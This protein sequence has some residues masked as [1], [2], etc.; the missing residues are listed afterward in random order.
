VCIYIHIYLF[1]RISKCIYI[2][3]YVCIFYMH[4]SIGR[5]KDVPYGAYVSDIVKLYGKDIELLLS[6]N[7]DEIGAYL[8]IYICIYIYMY[9][10]ICICI[11]KVCIHVYTLTLNPYPNP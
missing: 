6:M 11:D 2:Y 1:I 8:C 9:I 5:H 3:V 10:Y 4:I 7:A